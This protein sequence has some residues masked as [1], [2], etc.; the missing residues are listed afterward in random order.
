MA[1]E[2]IN[3]NPEKYI[4]PISRYEREKFAK[5]SMNSY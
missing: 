1:C 4:S 3:F 2:I 5:Y